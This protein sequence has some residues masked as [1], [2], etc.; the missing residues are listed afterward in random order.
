MAISVQ[1]IQ[2]AFEEYRKT[3]LLKVGLPAKPVE[4]TNG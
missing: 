1:E 4:E 3:S 2:A